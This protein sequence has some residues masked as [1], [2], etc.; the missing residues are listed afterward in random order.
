MKKITSLLALLMVLMTY[1]Q[2]NYSIKNLE[3][4]TK[5]SDFGVS[6]Y[7]NN[8]VFASSK[9]NDNKSHR[10]WVNGQR[11]LDLY[12]GV[13]DESGEIDESQPFSKKLNTKYHESNAAFT[14]DLKTVYF[15]RNN[16]YA[17][18]MVQDSTGYNNLMLYRAKINENGYWMQ[19]TPLPFNNRHYS[20]GHPSLSQDN[21]T[22]YFTSDMPGTSGHSDIFKVSINEDET[23]GSPINMGEQV[24][25]EGSEMFPFVTDDGNL[26]FSSDR[27]GG[28]GGLDVYIVPIE[29][30]RVMPINIGKPINSTVDDFA[31]IIDAH[32][33]TG[34]FSSNRETGKGDDDIYYFKELKAPYIPCSQE[35]SGIV[36]DKSNDAL[37]P[38]SNVYLFKGQQIID[39]LVVGNNAKFTFSNLNCGEVY[40]LTGTKNHY[41]KDK[42]M[43][44]TKINSDVDL[45]VDL[46]LA[47][48]IVEIAQ[49][50]SI[51][52]C[53][54]ALDDINTIYFDLD[55]YAIRPDAEVELN[56]I[57]A[58]MN[59][60]TDIK[61]EARSHTDS[62]AS[63]E[64][65]I[66]LSQNRAQSTVDYIVSKGISKERI[67]AKGFGENNL[68]NKCSDGVKCSN[69]EHQINRRTEFVIAR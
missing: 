48:D 47:P 30:H 39:S 59:E 6:Y 57:V 27:P 3:V 14:N 15:T 60:C 42:K 11:Y 61:I 54:Y 50:E 21:K 65:N 69:E 8:A 25:S 10:N 40:M 18:E 33:R 51:D 4:N 17:D 52:K 31:F 43:F 46:S 7:G 32:K 41:T 67:K 37:L 1:A 28:E 23:F 56:K 49:T 20:V 22:L 64:Y 38:N 45:E 55:K 34:Y 58:V 16:Y 63:N 12:T 2:D 68:L 36:K 66:T 53:Q 29:N 13:F 24:N 62:R 44:S 9:K 35:I 19:I 26:Y 5:Y